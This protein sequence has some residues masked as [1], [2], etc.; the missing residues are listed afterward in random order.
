MSQTDGSV[1]NVWQ[2]MARFLNRG[3]R[4]NILLA[5]LFVGLV[6][7]L[8]QYFLRPAIVPPVGKGLEISNLIRQVKSELEDANDKMRQNNEAALFQVQ[9]FDL[10]VTFVVQATTTSSG[11][12]DFHFVTVDNRLETNSQRTQKMTIHMV[13]TPPEHVQKNVNVS[14]SNVPPSDATVLGDIPPKKGER[15]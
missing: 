13:V 1:E 6:P 7:F 3:V 8:I 2:S 11:N 10:E 12:T 14:G 15:K 4:L 5:L 9:S